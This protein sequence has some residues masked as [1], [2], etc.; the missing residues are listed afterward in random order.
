MVFSLLATTS[1]WAEARGEHRF[2]AARRIQPFDVRN[3]SLTV[4]TCSTK[5]RNQAN[6]LAKKS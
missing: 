3:G 5:W 4:T 1:A 2:A 6:Y